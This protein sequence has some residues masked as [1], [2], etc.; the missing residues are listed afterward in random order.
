MNDETEQRI[1]EE[2]FMDPG[3]SYRVPPHVQRV[4]ARLKLARDELRSIRPYGSLSKLR[5]D[6]IADTIDRAIAELNGEAVRYPALEA[7][8][9]SA[10]D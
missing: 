3:Y 1:A 2:R 8:H 7:E 6:C 4:E 10:A 9:A 5:A